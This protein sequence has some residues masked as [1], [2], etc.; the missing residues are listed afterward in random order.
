VINIIEIGAG[1]GSTS[2][3]VLECINGFDRLRYHY[4]DPSS[5]FIQYSRQKFGSSYPLDFSILNIEKDIELQG[6]Q[7]EAYDIVIA[8][9]VLH[10]TSRIDRTLGQVRKLMR[11]GGILILNEVVR[12]EEFINLIFGLTN[13]W[14]LFEDSEKRIEQCPSLSFSGW[15]DE[16]ERAGFRHIRKFGLPDEKEDS[17]LQ[18][19]IVAEKEGESE[20][21]QKEAESAIGPEAPSLKRSD[22]I[23]S[24]LRSIIGKVSEI[25]PAEIDLHVNLF[26][27]GL[28]SLMLM[29]IR[30]AIKNGL[31]IAIKTASFYD[32]LDTVDKI[33]AYIDRQVPA[34]E[35]QEK[36]RPERERVSQ[37]KMPPPDVADKSVPFPPSGDFER[38]P[39]IERILTRQL[40]TMSKLM[41]D[42]M[43]FLRC[44][45]S[46]TAGDQPETANFRTVTP[47][48]LGPKE[49]PTRPTKQVNFRSVRLEEDQGLNE[50]QK[51][52]IERLITRYRRR[53]GKSKELA[54]RYRACL[55]DWKNTLSFR[56][57]LKEIIYPIVSVRSSGARF[58]DIDGN[59]YID[60]AM[61]CGMIFFG[62]NPDF[63]ER[64][65]QQQVKTGY[66]L[67]TQS[68]MAG[69]VSKLICELTGVERATFCNTGS[70][71]VMVA[72]RLARAVT[73]RS[74]IA[75][76]AGSY[77]GTFD[78]VLAISEE[79]S[80]FPTGPGTTRGMVEDVLVLHYGTSEALD[81]IRSQGRELAAVL[82]EPVQ[83][84]RPGFQPKEFLHELRKQTLETG[85]ALIFDEVITGFRIHPGGA[86]AW[87]GLEADMVTYGKVVG[88]GLPMSIVAGK[89]QYLDAID[90]GMWNYGD[91]SY[92]QRE[93][94]YFGG[95]Y[96]K[97]PLALSAAKAALLHMKEHGPALQEGVNR[98]T[99][100]LA[101]ELNDFFETEN[102]PIRL[103]Y[104]GSLFRF[105]SFGKYSPLLEPIEM[106]IFFHL[107]IEKGKDASVSF[108]QLIAMPT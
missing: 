39:E 5:V 36:E 69:E 50:V 29:Q 107:L 91:G 79:G 21:K 81:V 48:L 55:S 104:F 40:Q 88:G 42:Q 59:E 101:S 65:V 99:A 12:F 8:S 61:G 63:I 68:P 19:V 25:D 9:N 85:T 7:K 76:F 108:R 16:L 82:V 13:G 97:H 67:G 11:N 98:K 89:A 41:S 37:R 10:A 78:G 32:E 66:E 51:R 3:P 80:V 100:H 22:A 56:F 15:K 49:S 1:T 6:F 17:R 31:G 28:D 18:C 20:V 72:L 43:E 27:L 90:G 106:D 45:P 70:E 92:P 64:A 93:M 53:T 23:R 77:H 95:T 2:G 26:E 87:F 33:A 102:V 57:S 44:H 94:I 24:R 103:V 46:W 52:F 75:L 96:V 47:S 83:S 34:E 84:R 105:E 73:G 54:N 74:K 60:I 38:A 14:W 62:H 30:N 35:W 71:A 58:W 4:T 86:Q